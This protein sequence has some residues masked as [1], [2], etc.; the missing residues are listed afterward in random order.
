[1]VEVARRRVPVEDVPI[2]APAATLLAE[3]SYELKELAAG[4]RA[5]SVFEDEQI[6]EEH[7]RLGEKARVSFKPDRVGDRPLRLV[8][9]QR[10]LETRR[11]CK[12]V[13]AQAS[14]GRRVGPLETLVVG[15]LFNQPRKVVKTLLRQGDNRH[16]GGRTAIIAAKR[17]C[18][19]PPG[20]G[21][22]YVAAVVGP[23]KDGLPLPRPAFAIARITVLP[24]RRDV[25]R[26]CPPAAN[27]PG[28][29]RASTAHLVAAIP[30]EPP[31]P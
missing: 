5:S 14:H 18:A 26:N 15:E 4:A 24:N 1:M 19:V 8:E 3:L 9:G 31:T 22:L 2:H 20:G 17:H 21:G 10:R 28:I 25:P 11:R 12:C 16:R 23:V 29:V 30:L 7:R 6:L 27:L 13:G